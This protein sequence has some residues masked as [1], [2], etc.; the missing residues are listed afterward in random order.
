MSTKKRDVPT[1]AHWVGIDVSKGTFDA[2]LLSVDAQ[3]QG[4]PLRDLPTAAFRR[5]RDGV[6]EFLAWC[7]QQLAEVRYET[8]TRVVMEATGNYSQELAVWLVEEDSSLAPAIVNPHSAA[9]FMES[10]ALRNRTDRLCARALA[11]FGAQRR[12]VAYEPPSPEQAEVRE[13]SRYR[14]TLVEAKT[15]MGN[16]AG[17]GAQSKLVG[18]LQKRWLRQI[19]R[20]IKR[21]E[22][23]MRT[24]VDAI[25][26]LREDVRLLETIHGVGFITAVTVRVELGD[27]RRF[28]RARQLT[29]YA[30]VSPREGMSGTSVRKRTR[31][32]KAGN[33]RVRAVL[34]MAVCAGISRP[35]PMQTVHHRFQ[36][37]GL[38]PM[39]SIGALMRKHLVL[40]RAI[41][42][43]G[44]SYDPKFKTCGKPPCHAG[45]K[46]G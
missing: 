37:N 5:T 10:L 8:A 18:R 46:V 7:T 6:R 1:L 22:T 23:E 31:M 20:D 43:S 24:K 2:A 9:H 35:H 28:E 34:Y 44:Q 3:E 19:V 45:K 42:I 17:E 14:H 32:S 36:A 25:D 12:P 11:L 40:M 16:R 13:L 27:L 4:V 41:L 38:K 39:Q 29:A 21:V 15:A 30:G 33:A 26:G